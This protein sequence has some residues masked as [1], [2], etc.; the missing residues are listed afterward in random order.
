MYILNVKF[1]KM[2]HGEI[3]SEEEIFKCH[4]REIKGTARLP[5]IH[6]FTPGVCGYHRTG[7]NAKSTEFKGRLPEVSHLFRQHQRNA[8]SD[9]TG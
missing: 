6:Y 3:L 2:A 5:E 1:S 4:E 7:A 9:P 8:G